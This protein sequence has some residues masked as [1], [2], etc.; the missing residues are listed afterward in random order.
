MR[1]R[2]SVV[3]TLL[4]GTG[5]LV[6]SGPAQAE[7]VSEPMISVKS[8]T[9]LTGHGFGHGRGLS[10]YGAQGAA[11][12]GVQSAQIVNFYYPGTTVGSFTGEIRVL[13]GGDT[14]NDTVVLPTAGLAIADYG[15]GKAY[16]LPLN[17]AK[18]WK[19]F[20]S[21]GLTRVSYLS[22]A[23]WK[24]YA[25]GG[26]SALTGVGEFRSS[27]YKLTLRTPAGDRKYR[28]ALRY[29]NQ[30]TINRLSM[31][32]YLNGVVPLEMPASWRADA[33]EAQ[34][35]AA[36]SYAA[37]E[38]V[39]NPTRS[40]HVWDDPQYDQVYGGLSAE[41]TKSNAAVAATSGI[42]RMYAGKPAFTEFSSSNGG[43]S[44]A[45]ATQAY[46]VAQQDPYEKYSSNPNANWTVTLNAAALQKAYPQ[47]GTL[48]W[49]QITE[50][51]GNGDWGGRVQGLKLIGSAGTKE[52]GT[53]A[54][55][56]GVSKFRTVLGL[57]STYFTVTG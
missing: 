56:D 27:S 20:T 52:F 24:R 47:I 15:A 43:W 17:G 12:R 19:M 1:S 49:I 29:I 8:T 14:D 45:G 4:I 38:L 41:A 31:E 23:G 13:I 3:L 54:E 55:L 22:S 57:R 46:L 42:V 18:L 26:K 33:L 40:Y 34:S 6:S 35:I 30:N 2:F 16:K 7:P 21:D 25:L 37:R 36:R 44:S 53:A 32:S 28:G 51:D 48:K 11:L 39:D 9:K 50:R 5:L 10:Q